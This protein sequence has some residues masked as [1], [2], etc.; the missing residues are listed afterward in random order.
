MSTSSSRRKLLQG[1]TKTARSRIWRCSSPAPFN[2][3]RDDAIIPPRAIHS[4]RISPTKL[5][6][7]GYHLHLNAMDNV[8]CGFVRKRNWMSN[9]GGDFRSSSI[10]DHATQQIPIPKSSTEDPAAVGLAHA[11]IEQALMP[12]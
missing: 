6:R 2:P 12:S 1:L 5:R 7:R 4:P 8:K 11:I 10:R 9:G 3:C